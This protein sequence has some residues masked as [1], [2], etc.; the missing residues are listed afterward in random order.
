MQPR[1]PCTVPEHI[2]IKALQTQ[3]RFLP[4]SW[5]KRF[6]RDLSIDAGV[7]DKEVAQLWR[8]FIKYRR[9]IS[10]ERKAQL[11]EIAAENAAPDFRKL[12]AMAKEQAEIDS[13]RAKYQQSFKQATK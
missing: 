8:I 12:N 10:C 3:V 1:R 9:Q 7:T 13:L 11:L 2:A 6:A 4:A 5:D